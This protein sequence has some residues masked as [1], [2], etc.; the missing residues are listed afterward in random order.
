MCDEDEVIMKFENIKINVDFNLFA[1][2]MKNLLDN[3]IKYSSNKQVTIKTKDN[4]IIIENIGEKLNYPLED[5]FEPFFKGDDTKSNQSFGLGL[6]IIK[7]ILDAN[8]YTIEYLYQDGIN[9]FI[10]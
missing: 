7:H 6:Y 5:Y 2:A 1:I 8:G 4:K 3:G 9:R 10:I